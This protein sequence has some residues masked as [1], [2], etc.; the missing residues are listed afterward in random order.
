MNKILLS[1]ILTCTIFTSI[2]DAQA[3]SKRKKKNARSAAKVVP[4]ATISPAKPTSESPAPPEFLSGIENQTEQLI[5]K[6]I[7]AEIATVSQPVIEVK[8]KGTINWTDQFIEV[9]GSSAIDA[10]KF[11]NPAQAQLMAS[12]GAVVDAQRNLLEVIE[13]VKVTGETTVKDMVTESDVVKTKVEGVIKNARVLGEPIVK[14]GIATVTMRAPLYKD[15]L[16]TALTS[17]NPKSETQL[18]GSDSLPQ[19]IALRV[20][21]KY[22]PRLLPN[23]TDSQKNVLLDMAKA[24]DPT[25]GKFPEL[26]K[27]G[28]ETYE[29]LKGK[30]GLEIVDVLQDAAGNLVVP[31]KAKAKL[32]KWKKIG[33]TIFNIVKTILLPI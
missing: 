33:K 13:G 28:K 29:K 24:Y 27:T 10:T 9:T 21:G 6:D 17:G 8:P 11:P 23:L 32:E 20:N 4:S 22:D 19:S 15:G 7:E 25:N 26:L 1:L 16:A 12:R 31:D 14:N 2:I 30:K 5:P 3:Q 18:S